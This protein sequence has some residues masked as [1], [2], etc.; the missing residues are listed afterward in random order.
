MVVSRGVGCW[1][2][3]WLMSLL[4]TPPL[5]LWTSS[6]EQSFCVFLVLIYCTMASR[7]A[8]PI[9][10]HA[11]EFAALY[12]VTTFVFKRMKLFDTRPH[13]AAARVASAV[14]ATITFLRA[15]KLT[16]MHTLASPAKFASSVGM[17][18]NTE[19][20]EKLLHISCGYFL[21]DLLYIFLCERDIKFV[22]HHLISLTVWGTTLNAGRGCELANCCLLM[23]ES[24]TPILNAWW[25]AKQAGHE[26]L[27]RG[28]SRI[29][30]AGF[31]GVRVAILPFYVVPFANEALR[32]EDLEKRVGT[33]RA[34]LWAALVVLSMFG[35]LVWARSLV[36]GLLKDLR[37]GKRQIQAKPRAKQS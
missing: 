9:A 29:F 27:A 17:R 8:Q 13:M 24:T 15:A 10:Q 14:H 37:K 25:L 22:I 7:H 31:L 16:D 2:G 6:R 35:G 4:F 34:R 28:L 32:G 5:D 21:Y 11:A 19:A 3:P 1:P 36:R 12:A 30:T 20:D 18:E 23:G 26:R 33:L